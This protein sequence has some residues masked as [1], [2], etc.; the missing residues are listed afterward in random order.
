MFEM[1]HE[2]KGA[3]LNLIEH[4]AVMPQRDIQAKPMSCGISSMFARRLLRHGSIAG[5][6]SAWEAWSSLQAD[7]TRS[8]VAGFS[9]QIVED[10]LRRRAGVHGE[11]T[12]C[13]RGVLQQA[14]AKRALAIDEPP[15]SPLIN[16]ET[17]GKCGRSAK[18]LDA[19]SEVVLSILHR[20]IIA[21]LAMKAM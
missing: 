4:D 5:R 14:V 8:E 2:G 3:E 6:C 20:P 17:A 15:D 19:V 18:Q 1:R 10:G 16:P 9:G 7:L 11:V 12:Q 21:C 13:L